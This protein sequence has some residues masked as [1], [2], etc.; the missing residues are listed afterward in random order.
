MMLNRLFRVVTTGCAAGCVMA[1]SASGQA[2]AVAVKVI[3]W[4][5]V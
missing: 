2:A 4:K 5:R 1:T 3:Y